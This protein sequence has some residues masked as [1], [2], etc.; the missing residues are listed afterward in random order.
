VYFVFRKSNWYLF[1][2]VR[3][4]LLP[5]VLGQ[6]KTTGVPL[7]QGTSDCEEDVLDLIIFQ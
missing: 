1:G 3:A 6:N 5:G 2:P 7:L 4:R